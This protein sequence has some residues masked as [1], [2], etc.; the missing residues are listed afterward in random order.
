MYAATFSVSI[1]CKGG[2]SAVESG[3]AKTSSAMI[4]SQVAKVSKAC[5]SW[6]RE[7]RISC[8]RLKIDALSSS[9]SSID[10]ASRGNN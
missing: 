1:V 3:W 6:R 2:G 7:Y 4:V 5:R 10:L 8:E 9:P